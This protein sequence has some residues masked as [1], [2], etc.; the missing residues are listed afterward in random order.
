MNEDPNLHKGRCAPAGFQRKNFHSWQEHLTL[1]KGVY[2]FNILPLVVSEIWG[3][4]KLTL[5]GAAPPHASSAKFSY[6]KE[7]LPLSKSV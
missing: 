5:G 7:H 6:L 3:A 1:S 4:P 2:S